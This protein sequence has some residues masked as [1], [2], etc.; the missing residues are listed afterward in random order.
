[1][2]LTVV[3]SS[4]AQRSRV[5]A[6]D[7]VGCITTSDPNVTPGRITVKVLKTVH[8]AVTQGTKACYEITSVAPGTYDIQASNGGNYYRKITRVTL[9]KRVHT[10]NFI[11][12]EAKS[13]GSMT[14]V[15]T[16]ADGEPLAGAVV[17]IYPPE[18]S[19]CKIVETVTGAGGEW[20]LKRLAPEFYLVAIT[21]KKTD[22]TQSLAYAS[23]L[24][25]VIP[26]QPVA[27]D[28]KTTWLGSQLSVVANVRDF[29][30]PPVRPD[31]PVV[32]YSIGRSIMGVITD[33]TGAA[34]P[35]I[36]V[37][38]I[39]PGLPPASGITNE[40]GS[41]FILNVDH[42]TTKGFRQI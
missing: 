21:S 17:S 35:G 22:G 12:E 9:K 20:A 40:E 15:A 38:A 16:T 6:V 13:P 32:T 18:C 27:M 1:M 41:F 5:K 25:R 7:I 30:S 37:V 4:V 19:D 11:L 8:K 39:R 29:E 36:T 10:V 2:V 26:D 34:I 31:T 42:R 3:D 28:L 23:K 33:S 14:G 24:V